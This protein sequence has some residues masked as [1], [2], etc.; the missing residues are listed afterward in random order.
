MRLVG[1]RTVSGIGVVERD[2]E[3]TFLSEV[4]PVHGA[5]LVLVARGNGPRTPDEMLVLASGSGQVTARI[6]LDGPH[7]DLALF[8]YDYGPADDRP[9]TAV[10]DVLVARTRLWS[11]SADHLTAFALDG[12]GIRWT[13]RSKGTVVGVFRHDTDV[14]AVS[15]Y[16]APDDAGSGPDGTVHV[17][18]LEGSTGAVRAV[19]R[20][21]GYQ[22]GMRGR[23]HL[24]REGHLFHTSHE[25]HHLWSP[26]Q[27]FRLW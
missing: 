24:D 7:G 14:V 2:E 20:L 21:R 11:I 8:P 27:M 10:A 13:W 26:V 18:L 16:V 12:E 1:M 6:P 23:Y 5:P 22:A 15:K 19:R 25:G 9:V 17:H 3:E 4:V